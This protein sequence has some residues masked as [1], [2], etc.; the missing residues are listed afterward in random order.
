MTDEL[1]TLKDFE[2]FSEELD[3]N[4]VW[5]DELREEAVKW[6]RDRM[7]TKDIGTKLWETEMLAQIRFIKNFFNLTEEDLK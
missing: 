5:S 6:V 1:K 3:D 2:I 4:L 7:R